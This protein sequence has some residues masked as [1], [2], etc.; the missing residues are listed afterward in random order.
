MT[1]FIDYAFFFRS[2]ENDGL[3]TPPRFLVREAGGITDRKIGDTFGLQFSYDINRNISFD[4][5]STYFISGDFIKASGA[6][7]NIFYI[8]PTLNFRF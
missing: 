6:S 4:L 7:E 3:Y 8:A 2:S 1:A 5:R